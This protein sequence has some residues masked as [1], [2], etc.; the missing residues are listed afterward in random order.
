[1]T[2]PCC[3]FTRRDLLRWS[4]LVAATP[5]L[6]SLE[7][8]PRAYGLTAQVASNPALPIN[9]ELVTLTETTAIVTWFTGD[10]TRPDQMGRLA[11]MPADTSVLLATGGGALR[12]VHYDATPTPYHYVEVTGL[13]PGETYAIVGRSNGVVALPSVAYGGNPLG[14]SGATPTPPPIVF[15]TPQPPPGRYLFSVALC[16]DLHLGEKTAGLATSLA[17]QGLPPGVQQLPGKTPYPRIMAAALA[18]EAK[19]RGA[20]VLLAAGDVSSE[21]APGDLHAAR[22]FLD[23]F[24]QYQRDYFVARGNHDRAHDNPDTAS[25]GPSRFDSHYHDCYVDEFDAP[26]WFSHDA[27]GMRV[28]GIDTYDTIGNGA[29]EG[30]MSP[31]QMSFVREQLAKNKEQP[32]LVFGHH[33]VPLDATYNSLPP[34][35]FGLDRT[36]ARALEQL[37]A[38]T[39]GVF[40][41]HAGHTHR[42]KKS[43]S[44]VAPNVTFQEVCAT[45]EYP[46]G[47]HLLRVFSGGY[48]LNFYKFKDP[49]ALE[50]SERSRPEYLG[51]YP[52]YTLGNAADRNSVTLRDLS[53]LHSAADVR[54]AQTTTSTTTPPTVAAEQ[55]PA[56]GDTPAMAAAATAAA[57]GAAAWLRRASASR[58]DS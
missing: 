6:M 23:G 37:Y 58:P 36:Q 27:F 33:P 46:G 53:G 49:L 5:I 35:I 8:M 54:A 55:L 40:L 32:T 52:F 57:A 14:S 29:F 30:S 15:T 44:L 51:A 11:P 2:R 17:G 4:T 1:V 38:Q 12:E 34:V 41:H 31:K 18:R 42:N 10:P 24:G 25:C 47:F 43:A 20:D 19:Q 39:P 28:L 9:F 56:T 22:G 21:A 50:W 48:A 13:E 26:T 7:D 3:H 16:N 45:K